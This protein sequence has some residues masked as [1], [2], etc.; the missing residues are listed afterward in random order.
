MESW[1]NENYYTTNQTKWVELMNLSTTEWSLGFLPPNIYAI[2]GTLN[3]TYHFPDDALVIENAAETNWGSAPIES[4]VFG[5][6]SAVAIAF[7]LAWSYIQ[8]RNGTLLRPRN[9]PSTNRQGEYGVLLSS[10][11]LHGSDSSEDAEIGSPHGFQSAEIFKQT[12]FSKYYESIVTEIEE[13]DKK[14][15][16]N[17]NIEAEDVEA[18]GD[19][20]RKIYG[21]QFDILGQ[22]HAF[23]PEGMEE[24]HMKSKAAIK[25]IRETVDIWASGQMTDWNNAERRHLGRLYTTLHPTG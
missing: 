11:R 2:P 5:V 7:I 6:T 16:H 13:Y 19:V 18:V 21:F 3:D 4:V 15:S 9:E 23:Q 24:K 20:L 22:Q 17:D 10:R 8:V 25:D 1:E 12:L 14:I